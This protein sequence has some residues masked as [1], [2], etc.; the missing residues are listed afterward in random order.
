MNAAAMMK[1]RGGA[2]GQ[3]Y[4]TKK[5]EEKRERLGKSKRNQI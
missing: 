5:G 3:R 2:R 4:R 1:G